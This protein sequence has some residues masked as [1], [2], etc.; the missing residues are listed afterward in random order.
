MAQQVE[1]ADGY[2][3]TLNG[4]RRE[5]NWYLHLY[6]NDPPLDESLV[7]ADFVEAA[8]AGY[9][10]QPAARWTPPVMREGKA[11]SWSD[12]VYFTWTGGAAT[13]PIRGYYATHGPDGSLARVWRPD[14]DP[15]ILSEVNRVLTIFIELAYPPG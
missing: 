2:L 1:P 6:V 9:A 5:T 10:P 15:V 7:V 8:Y 4:I 11:R 12:P 14:G 3:D 13:P